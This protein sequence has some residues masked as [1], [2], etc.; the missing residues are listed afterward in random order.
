MKTLFWL[1]LFLIFYHYLLFPILI[2]V[3]AKIRNMTADKK[4]IFPSVS[5][6]IAAYNEEKVIRE[7]ILNSLNLNYP[8]QYIEI[9]VVSDGSTDSTPKIVQE[10]ES[11]GVKSVFSPPRKGKTAALNHGVKYA[12]GEIIVFS[13]ANSM[14]KADA[15]NKLIRNFNDPSIGG[16]CGRKS[17]VTNR[18]RESS[19][20]D[21]LFWDFESTIKTWQGQAGSISNADGEIFAIRH[22]LYQDIPEEIINDD[23]IITFDIISK[24]CRVI[25]EP[26]A[27]SFEEASIVLED[28][29]KVKARMV[30]GGYQIIS[31]YRDTLFPPNNYFAFQFISH[32]V[33]RYVMPF[34][35]ITLFFSNL[36]ITNGIF[37]YVFILQVLFYCAA[38][39]GFILK[40][41]N[42]KQGIFYIPNYYCIMNIAAIY[43]FFYY[44]RGSSGVAVW[45]KA[46]R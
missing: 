31:R 17:I 18:D 35:L 10:Y 42:I 46:A 2:F 38:L 9:I 33:L 3:M 34:F 20:G 30:T 32:K 24:G 43:G 44:F 8:P 29:F 6:I 26:E 36:F 15:I 45:K 14:F 16:V 40:K 5:F 27:V 25:Y 22:S 4:E 13:D 11:Q 21:S 1:M 7:K 39:I 41:L 12:T 37:L 28:D 19:K 23:Q